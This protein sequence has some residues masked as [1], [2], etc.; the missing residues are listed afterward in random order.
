MEKEHSQKTQTES[1]DDCTN[2]AMSSRDYDDRS[3]GT[4]DPMETQYDTDEYVGAI[5]DIA[6]RTDS[7]PV[8]ED[9]IM[10]F[11]VHQHVTLTSL[12]GSTS[13]CF[14]KRLGS[15]T[16]VQKSLS[17]EKENSEINKENEVSEMNKEKGDPEN[18]GKDNLIIEYEGHHG[19]SA[20]KSDGV[21][22]KGENVEF[23]KL[24]E[25]V[26]FAIGYG[27]E[28]E[29]LISAKSKLDELIRVLSERDED[30]IFLKDQLE[31]EKSAVKADLDFQKNKCTE[32]EKEISSIRAE[33]DC[34][35]AEKNNQKVINLSSV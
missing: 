10:M 4:V 30:I 2:T 17:K 6:T 16:L 13:R 1:D 34:V 25:D 23:S 14:E 7:L 19:K 5:V 8:K 9:D 12:R 32:M 28:N 35:K 22:E 26:G 27:M 29:E 3:Y 18:L 20:E 33:L 21:A 11:N 15:K 24:N 31:A